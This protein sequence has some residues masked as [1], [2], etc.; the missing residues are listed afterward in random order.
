MDIRA[1]SEDSELVNEIISHNNKW[2]KDMGDED[3]QKQ[4]LLTK[5]RMIIHEKFEFKFDPDFQ[6]YSIDLKG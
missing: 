1:C 3:A 2:L 6:G 4:Y 5:V